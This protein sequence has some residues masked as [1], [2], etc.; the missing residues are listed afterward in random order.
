MPSPTAF[1]SKNSFFSALRVAFTWLVS[2]AAVLPLAFYVQYLDVGEHLGAQFDGV[3]I[4]YYRL[5]RYLQL[6]VRIYFIISFCVPLAIAGSFLVKTSSVTSRA[7]DEMRLEESRERQ[8]SGNSSKV[9]YVVDQ[10]TKNYNI[11]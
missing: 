9:R 7:T 5:E 2:L 6:F 1:K 10:N 8:N 4:C 3:G 11:I